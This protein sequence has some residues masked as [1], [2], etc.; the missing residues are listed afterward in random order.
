M[1]PTDGKDFFAGDVLRSAFGGV[2]TGAEAPAPKPV[3]NRRPN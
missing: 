2:G 1:V 3:A